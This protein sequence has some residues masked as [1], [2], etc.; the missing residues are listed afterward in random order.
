MLNMNLPRSIILVEDKQHYMHKICNKYIA[1]TVV[2][3][4][5]ENISTYR[6]SDRDKSG[7]F[8]LQNT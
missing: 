4:L 2:V 8:L 7:E 6:T 1:F 3:V 5:S